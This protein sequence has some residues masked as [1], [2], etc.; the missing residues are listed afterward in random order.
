MSTTPDPHDMSVDSDGI[1]LCTTHREAFAEGIFAER[2]R[3]AARLRE[4]QQEARD[5]YHD[6][7]P[8]YS[9][10]GDAADEILPPDPLDT[11]TFDGSAPR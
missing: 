1:L 11:M 2:F 4:L 6:T 10:L 7:G 9:M 8:C 5:G 3:M